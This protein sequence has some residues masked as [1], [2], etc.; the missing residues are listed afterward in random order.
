MNHY[1]RLKVS[2]DAP[3]EVIR[4]A[5]RALAAKLHP[6]RQ[7]QGGMDTGPDDAMHA[8]MAAL[9][10]AYEVLI[11]PKLRLEYDA[12]LAPSRPTVAAPAS[13]DAAAS[14]SDNGPSTRVDM[15]W[16]TPKPAASTMN[17]PPSQRTMVLGGGVMAAVVL[18][19]GGWLYKMEGQHRV[20]QALS[21]Q[22]AQPGAADD[23]APIVVP[24]AAPSPT[25]AE[26]SAAERLIQ[27]ELAAAEKRGKP[28][29][30]TTRR[31]SV[32][33]LSRMSDEELLKVL[34]TLD[35]QGAAAE[36]VPPVAAGTGKRAATPTRASTAPTHHPLD[37][38]P[39]GLRTDMQLPEALPSQQA[40]GKGNR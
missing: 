27:Q 15:E 18:L 24:G 23:T 12:T 13:P 36:P 30:T 31:P 7:Q 35:G 3:P 33:E 11:D 40:A 25:P 4:A 38:K 9:N 34:P 32:E 28:A 21:G 2:Q 29:T 6:D 1:E 5:Y 39:L 8:Q 19:G 10:Q 22:Y 37:G 14:A 20:E 17:W 16:L 26:V